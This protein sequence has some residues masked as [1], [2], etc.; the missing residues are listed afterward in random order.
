MPEQALAVAGGLII[1][2][3]MVY[4]FLACVIAVGAPPDARRA[5][6]SGGRRARA[7]YQRYTALVVVFLVAVPIVV[8]GGLLVLTGGYVLFF[9]TVF[10][11]PGMLALLLRLAY[12]G[13]S[14]IAYDLRPTSRCLAFPLTRPR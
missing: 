9:W 10:A 11:G 3:P 12:D 4:G 6:R 5:A 14:G 2:A 13:V 8:C 1:L 7:D